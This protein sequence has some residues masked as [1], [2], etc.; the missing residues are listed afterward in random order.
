MMVL[1]QHYKPRTFGLPITNWNPRIGNIV[2]GSFLIFL[3][4]PPQRPWRV[5]LVSIVMKIKCN[6][7][8]HNVSRTLQHIINMQRLRKNLIGSSLVLFVHSSTDVINGIANNLP[9][10]LFHII[11]NYPIRRTA[12][13]WFI[14]VKLIRTAVTFLISPSANL[15]TFFEHVMN[16]RFV[17]LFFWIFI[18]LFKRI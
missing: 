5:V 1:T 18:F 8:R 11:A 13:L 10:S 12:E 16:V 7:T 2:L 9:C 3:E 17:K 14:L 15:T 6:S 4:N